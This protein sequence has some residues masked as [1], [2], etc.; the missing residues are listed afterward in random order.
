MKSPWQRLGEWIDTQPRAL[1]LLLGVFLCATLPMFFSWPEYPLSFGGREEWNVYWE[2]VV[3]AK[4]DDPWHDYTR[5]YSPEKNE[6][7]RNFRLTIP[8]LAHVSGTRVAGVHALRF[9]LHAVLLVALM[10]AAE[11]A[12]GDRRA[13]WAT[14]LAV[15]GTYVGTS[16]WR[17]MCLWF[18]NCA[19]AF[20]ALALLARRPWSACALTLLAAFTDERA[21]LTVPLLLA[22]HAF[23]HSR[24]SVLAGIAAAV[25]VYL[26]L[27]LAM[28]HRMQGLPPMA[29]IADLSIVIT[30]LKSAPLSYWFAL[31]GGW[32]L[33]GLALQRALQRRDLAGGIWLL[34]ATAVPVMA[35][36]AVGD[37]TRSASY[38][39][40]AT[41]AAVALL[42]R[43][44][45]ASPDVGRHRGV[46]IAAV[47][48][49]LVPN[50]MIMHFVLIEQSMPV[51]AVV[52]WLQNRIAP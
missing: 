43:S 3:A 30:N 46:G 4:V 17:D 10:L 18:D 40:P 22:F 21:L 49:L 28:A 41:L 26:V 52:Q 19:H 24:Q 33:V 38:A 11:R 20:M 42:R 44:Q 29:G 45:L 23:T 31:E 15:A 34:L 8:A 6:A 48:S 16:V 5:R 25:P 7:K 47:V 14:A 32:I 37:F 2:G 27:R 39:F 13:A 35:S 51:R 50:V 12:A 1:W 9:A 36:T